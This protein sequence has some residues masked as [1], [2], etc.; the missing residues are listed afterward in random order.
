MISEAFNK[1]A[2]P[3]VT[4]P[5]PAQKQ[6]KLE[7]LKNFLN[8]PAINQRLSFIDEKNI[9]LIK[10]NILEVV[11]SDTKL[12]QCSPAAIVTEAM[13]AASL[14]LPINRSLGF[15]YFLPFQN[16]KKLPDGSYSKEMIPTFVIGY[17]GLIQLAMRTGQYK[18]INSDV[19]YEGEL[20]NKDKLTGRIDLS[21]EQ[22]SEKI[23]GYFA[24]LELMNGFSKTLYTPLETM[25]AYAKKN[26]PSIKYSKDVTIDK[27]ITL[28]S[29][30][31]VADG[32]GWT[33]DFT[34]MALKTVLRTL[35]SKYGVLSIEMQQALV[36]DGDYEDITPNADDNQPGKSVVDIT[37]VE[38]KEEGGD[39]AGEQGEEAKPNCGF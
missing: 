39:P 18:Y 15:A 25:A 3:A 10:A 17:K 7:P 8:L 6:S 26:S 2:T 35:L 16:S 36:E 23:I 21:G 30:G 5:Q 13:K 29:I 12:Q 24:H 20:K 11:S 32:V 4:N 28:G 1:P 34:S 37:D 9:D 14:K 38:Y 22:K 31:N 19:V 33:A 27:L